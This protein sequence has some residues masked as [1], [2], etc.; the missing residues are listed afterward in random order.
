M[1]RLNAEALAALI[2]RYNVKLQTFS[3]DIVAAARK[4]AADIMGELSARSDIARRIGESYAG[5]RSRT[6]AWSRVSLKAVL[7]ARDR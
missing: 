6:A 3:G 1:D 7:E 4:Q 5:F 2:D